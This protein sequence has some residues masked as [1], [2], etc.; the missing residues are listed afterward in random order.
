MYIFSWSEIKEC[1]LGIFMVERIVRKPF[2][3]YIYKC[4]PFPH[5]AITRL[6][7]I[8]LF[9]LNDIS[10]LV[11]ATNISLRDLA[12]LDLTGLLLRGFNVLPFDA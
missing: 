3:F 2:G 4:N 5:Q 10:V 9:V 8:V 1:P 7:F 6:H 11:T 12:L